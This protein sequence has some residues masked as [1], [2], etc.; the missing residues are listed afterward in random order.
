MTATHTSPYA[1]RWYPAD[2]L[3]LGS[4]L[5]ELFQDSE[6]RTPFVFPGALGL[7]VPHAG[8]AYSGTVAAASYRAL[9]KSRSERVVLLAFPHRGGL[10]GVAAPEVEAISTPLGTVNIDP[11]FGG[12]RQVAEQRVCDHSFEIQ[13]PF[14]QRV[15]PDAAVTPLYVGPMREE[16]RAEA[17][18]ALA[19]AWHPGV[20]F[21]ASSDFTHYGASFDFTP[22]PPDDEAPER[23]RELDFACI[24]AAATL[25]SGRFLDALDSTGATVCGSGPIALLLDVMKRVDPGQYL[26]RLDYQT[27]GEKERDY[28]HS[29]SY[30]ALGCFPRASYDLERDDRELL[31][32]SAAETLRELRES[33]KRHPRYVQGGSA[34]LEARRGAFVTLTQG[35]ELLGCIGNRSGRGAL[36]RDIAD[37]ALSAATEDPRFRP[38]AGKKGPIDIE[39][40]ILTPFRRIFSESECVVGRHGVYLEKGTHAGLLL[41]QVASE[42]GW[43]S[44][45]FLEALT[46][47]S[48]L[49]PHVLRDPETSLFVF[50]A[51]VFSR[52]RAA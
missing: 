43:T 48:Y 29:V 44:S 52:E 15:V 32:N 4:L 26:T 42:R 19:R 23:I 41:P 38:A 28:H 36:A 27:S 10:K 1:G 21:V 20:V 50:E 9:A 24:E 39:I 37:L 35:D 18:D 25:D 30:A 47:K 16:E 22:F 46:R 45:E 11:E 7:V 40:S 33:R 51:Q 12:F 13:L 6:R 49:G 8:P 14:L 2:E 17:A 5:D 31:L 3:E 34:A